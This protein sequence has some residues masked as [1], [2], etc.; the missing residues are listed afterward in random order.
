M[1]SLRFIQI[2]LEFGGRVQSYKFP[3]TFQW[4]LV[5]NQPA[6]SINCLYLLIWSGWSDGFPS[7]FEESVPLFGSVILLC[8]DTLT[9]PVRPCRETG[10]LKRQTARFSRTLL[11]ANRIFFSC[12]MFWTFFSLHLRRRSC[13]LLPLFQSNK[14]LD[15]KS[16]S[17][18]KKC[19][20]D[21]FKNCNFS[22]KKYRFL[23]L[24]H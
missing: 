15:E 8:E 9:G 21:T 20:I 4:G 14:A 10:H 2:F 13:S 17:K 24:K 19:G 1:Y 11:F 16:M 18:Q 5:K 7:S 23:S 3:S 6:I 22:K 12:E